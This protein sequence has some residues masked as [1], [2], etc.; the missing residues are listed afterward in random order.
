MSVA[1]AK[2]AVALHRTTPSPDAST[3]HLLA[4]V[5]LSKTGGTTMAVRFE[6]LCK[7]HPSC[8]FETDSRILQPHERSQYPC[9]AE[10]PELLLLHGH[11]VSL[12]TITDISIH[13]NNVQG[14][15]PL[16]MLKSKRFGSCR[17]IQLRPSAFRV[18]YVTTMREPGRRMASAFLQW[19]R[20][21]SIVTRSR[22]TR[23][24]QAAP[25]VHRFQPAVF[26]QWYNA[27]I[28]RMRAC[29]QS[30]LQLTGQSPS[31][32]CVAT[33]AKLNHSILKAAREVLQMDNFIVLLS[34]YDTASMSLLDDVLGSW[35]P[36]STR[37]DHEHKVSVARIAAQRSNHNL[38]RGNVSYSNLLTA[39]DVY[40]RLTSQ[41]GYE[42][43]LWYVGSR[44]FAARH[45]KHPAATEM[46]DIAP[47]LQ[48]SEICRD[49]VDR[50]RRHQS[51]H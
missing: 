12:R 33:N 48:Q 16:D 34:E 10:I 19:L 46:I 18:L 6:T 2:H 9:G 51:M 30:L 37:T 21:R 49:T 5:H 47:Y 1:A 50:L 8:R 22:A 7:Q 44:A 20:P 26:L 23:A 24:T 36:R 43:W 15:S 28:P 41:L 25:L 14:R 40:K 38:R 42:C 11:R 17:P 35:L 13:G 27:I 3:S 45:N 29:A 32:P 4:Y 39:P 31:T